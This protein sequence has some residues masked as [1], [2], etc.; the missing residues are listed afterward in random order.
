MAGLDAWL[1]DLD[2]DKAQSDQNTGGECVGSESPGNARGHIVHGSADDRS[3]GCAD[4][5]T[6]ADRDDGASDRDGGDSND[7]TAAVRL[8]WAIAFCCLLCVHN[9]CVSARLPA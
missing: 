6:D 2:F 8:F 9:S 5:G 7:T 1:G 3:G 4:D